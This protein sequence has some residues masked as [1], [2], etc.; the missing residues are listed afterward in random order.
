MESAPPTL[1]H[2]FSYTTRVSLELPPGWLGD[3]AAERQVIYADAGVDPVGGDAAFQP[4]LVV[5][6]AEAPLPDPEAYRVLSRELLASP[7]EELEPVAH[8]DV[9]VDGVDGVLDVFRYRDPGGDARVTQLQVFTQLGEV[10][11]SFSGVVE[12]QHEEA[13]LPVFRAAIASV[14]FIFPWPEGEEG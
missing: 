5:Q 3:E 2:H 11:F 14:R 10:G 4:K 7:L 12:A 8:E 9:T 13:Y 1:V 6:V